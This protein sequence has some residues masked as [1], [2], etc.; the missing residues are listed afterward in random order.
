[1]TFLREKYLLPCAFAAVFL[2]GMLASA[3]IGG[4][5]VHDPTPKVLEAYK[6]GKQ[7]ALTIKRGNTEL[8]MTCAALWQSNQPF[9]GE[10]K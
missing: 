4:L 5:I 8:E 9:L 10:H 1:M 7:D 2:C 3:F 6:R